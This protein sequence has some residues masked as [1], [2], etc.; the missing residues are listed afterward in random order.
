MTPGQVSVKTKYSPKSEVMNVTAI[1]KG[2]EGRVIL[3]GR[4]AVNTSVI[5]LLY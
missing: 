5:E 4:G 2:K 1:A 3:I